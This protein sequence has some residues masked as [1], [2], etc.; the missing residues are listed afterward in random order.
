M[1][2]KNDFTWSA[3]VTSVEDYPIEIHKGYI[4]TQ[5]KFITAIHNS[6]I[7]DEGWGYDGT[8]I[9]AGGNIIP[10]ML[11][12]TWVSYAE[13]K[14]WNIETTIDQTTQNKILALFREGFYNWDNV[15]KAPKHSTYNHITIAV[16]PGGVVVIFITGTAHRK[17]V[18]RY[19]A[20]ETF[21]DVN[22]FYDNPDGDNQQEFYDWWYKKSV[23]KYLQEKIA[24]SG[25][26]YGIWDIYR[27]KY[28]WRFQ[29]FF[30][31][32]DTLTDLY[33][34]YIN[35]E[36]N[37]MNENELAKKNINHLALPLNVRFYYKIYNGEAKFDEEEI[38]AAF[39]KLKK[40]H[41]DAT[42]EIEVRPAFMYK[43][44]TFT[45]KCEGEEIPLEKTVVK[46]YK[47]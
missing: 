28:N 36:A 1:S 43:S 26:P 46:M 5:D 17:E 19:Q 8:D 47:N 31:K 45:V 30:Y 2:N 11:S 29:T 27:E 13:K 34:S 9:S 20:K 44:T 25:I 12:L 35:G 39:K 22:A 40:N 32:E 7:E 18:A 4:A 38:V 21:V 14:F 41:P 24:K 15:K 23:P 10:T 42:I 3:T 16:A 37:Y 6:G 33:V